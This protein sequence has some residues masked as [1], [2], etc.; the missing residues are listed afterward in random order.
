M[1][2]KKGSA[3]NFPIGT[4]EDG[5]AQKLNAHYAD[6][7]RSPAGWYGTATVNIAGDDKIP[8]RTLKFARTANGWDVYVLAGVVSDTVTVKTGKFVP[9]GK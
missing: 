3:F 5:A 2:N 6:K 1:K 9:V 8:A 7:L 4:S